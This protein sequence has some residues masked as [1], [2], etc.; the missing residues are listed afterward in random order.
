MHPNSFSDYIVYVDE[1][2]DHSL[3]TINSE[4]PLFVLAFCIFK[5]DIYLEL[6]KE[7][8]AFKF[9][10]FGH[11]KVIF[12]ENEIRHRL[13][14]F[15]KFDIRMQENFM[16]EYW[17]IIEQVDFTVIATVINKLSFKQKYKT[18]DNPYHLSM[19]FCLER[20]YYFLNNHVPNVC[21]THIVVEQRGKN[22]DQDLK[23]EFKR[24]CQ[25]K[26]FNFRLRMASKFTNCVGL[27]VAD[28]IAR[29]IGI[30]TL[31]PEQHNRGFEIVKSKFYVY[32]N[33][34]SGYGLKIFP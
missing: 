33:G 4:Y 23:L 31:R 14:D 22:E 34:F 1:S 17:K 29:P 30:S 5:K 18:P 27:Q 11:D 15:R 16:A 13:N 10:W 24:V 9:K 12:H 20:L 8:T 6:V 28:L 32:N 21:K 3:K 26:S 7:V 25:N 19:Q 2:G